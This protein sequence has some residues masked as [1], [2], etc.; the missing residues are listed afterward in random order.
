MILSNQR[1]VIY[2]FLKLGG[3]KLENKNWELADTADVQDYQKKLRKYIFSSD[4]RV[5]ISISYLLYLRNT[6]DKENS[7][8]LSEL[9]GKKFEAPSDLEF[10]LR[11]AVSESQWETIK[12]DLSD[13]SSGVLEAAILDTTRKLSR[14]EEFDTPDTLVD[15]VLGLLGVKAG[16]KVC[17]I[18][19]GIG[20][21]TVKAFLQQPEASYYSKDINASSSAVMEI[22]KDIL[23]SHFG[24][25]DIHTETGNTLDEEHAHVY[26]KVFGNYPWLIDLRGGNDAEKPFLKDLNK[27][28]GGIWSRH[29][30]D[31][32][33]NLLMV[34]VMKES[35]KAIGIMTN[36]S[37]WNQVAGC[38]N[39]RRYFLENGLIEAVIALPPRVF[40][41]T[42]IPVTMIILSHGND[43]VKMVDASEL[44]TEQLR[45]NVFTKENITEIISAYEADGEHSLSVNVEDILQ[46]ND[47]AIHPSRY[48]AKTRPVKKGK[49]LGSVLKALYRGA[50][51]VAK[52]LDTLLTNKPS[53]Y[54]FVRMN[55]INDG[56]IDTNLP[57]VSALDKKYEK[58][59]APHRSLLLSKMG[60]PFKCAIV[61]D[62]ERKILVNGNMFILEVDETK[63]NPYYLKAL[64]ESDYGTTLL[65]SICKVTAISTFGKKA[66]EELVIPLPSL[67]KQ[68][69]IADTYLRLRDEIQ[70]Y[71]M[72]LARASEKKS[73]IFDDI[74]ED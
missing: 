67:E 31:W 24:N 16:E 52:E 30:S 18:C 62:P 35:G 59:I 12:K 64:F 29:V 2:N 57:Y 71:K 44:C 27:E 43:K 70:L 50:P 47:T 7:L 46:T 66:L 54:Q 32:L 3:A 34:H 68:N 5:G 58:F 73:H 28:I 45:Q 10:M 8:S 33:F 41:F 11:D 53:E 23:L 40:S 1:M 17:D 26:D 22:R 74:E 55:Q 65:A 49:P 38:K 63:A 13:V 61:E 15:L 48:L 4:D 42:N 25:A 56:I 51:I 39:A 6:Y 37:T 14:T 20:N 9:L 69:Q 19:G 36:G 21:F 60:A 72:K